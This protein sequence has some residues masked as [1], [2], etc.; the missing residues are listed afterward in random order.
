MVL[1]RGVFNKAR[2]H[3]ANSDA[4]KAWHEEGILPRVQDVFEAVYYATK[5]CIR[6][7][8]IA[9]ISE[10]I[11]SEKIRSDIAACKEASRR[12]QRGRVH[13]AERHE[14]PARTYPLEAMEKDHGTNP[15]I[16]FDDVKNTLEL[17]EH[18]RSFQ[19]LVKSADPK[20][21]PRSVVQLSEELLAVLELL[22]ARCSATLRDNLNIG[23]RLETQAET[24]QSTARTAAEQVKH[25]LRALRQ[26]VQDESAP[27]TFVDSILKAQ[28]VLENLEGCLESG[29]R[30]K[31]DLVDKQRL[32]TTG[33]GRHAEARDK[34]AKIRSLVH[35]TTGLGESA[36][37][38]LQAF[39][40]SISYAGWP[41]PIS[42]SSANSVPAPTLLQHMRNTPKHD[43]AYQPDSSPLHKRDDT[44]CSPSCT[45]PASTA[46]HWDSEQPADASV[47]VANGT[48]DSYK[49]A[50][51]VSIN[52]SR[53][54]R[55]IETAEIAARQDLLAETSVD[56][57][58]HTG[59]TF[60]L[61]VKI[62]WSRRPSST[63]DLPAPW[64]D[65]TNS[66]GSM[67][68][69]TKSHHVAG[70]Q[71]PVSAPAN[72]NNRA[73]KLA[74]LSA[75]LPAALPAQDREDF[76]ADLQDG[77][78]TDDQSV[79]QCAVDCDRPDSVRSEL[80]SLGSVQH[81]EFGRAV[82]DGRTDL[83]KTEPAGVVRSR[84]D[85]M[86]SLASHG[87]EEMTARRQPRLAPINGRRS[88]WTSMGSS[89]S[90]PVQKSLADEHL[91]SVDIALDVLRSSNVPSPIPRSSRIRRP[92]CPSVVHRSPPLAPR[93]MSPVISHREQSPPVTAAATASNVH[94]SP[95]LPQRAMSV[96]SHRSVKDWA[97]IAADKMMRRQT[98]LSPRSS[99][100]AEYVAADPDYASNQPVRATCSAAAS[101]G[102]RV[103]ANMVDVSKA[104][105][106]ETPRLSPLPDLRR[107]Q[108]TP[109]TMPVPPAGP[110][111]FRSPRLVSG[112]P[113]RTV[114]RR[115][116]DAQGNTQ[117]HDDLPSRTVTRRASDA[118]GNTQAHDDLPGVFNSITR[119]HTGWRGGQGRGLGEVEQQHVRTA[120]VHV[121][122]A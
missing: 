121:Y 78:S 89:S 40:E 5:D 59:D 17:E 13:A 44:A 64:A 33:L 55:R 83:I 60:S 80:S 22:K 94:Q 2:V 101:D 98:P 18:I 10:K 84:H 90:P 27:A 14:S 74:R 122:A 114:T 109:Q 73:G 9:C 99:L 53:G 8:K 118:Q 113:S 67:D 6:S 20:L 97:K 93:A 87:W 32:G 7:E 106:K 95:P 57:A 39:D 107:R 110:P 58:I 120:S 35:D 105:A 34:W 50:P 43:K 63:N 52:G 30:K 11:R 16:E 62:D 79:S 96:E 47:G 66:D 46:P 37:V 23:M 104:Y 1:H 68:N 65:A 12:V 41:F 54:W 49:P 4:G 42:T 91:V 77:C 119:Q 25:V 26:H 51:S 29:R 31:L 92:S 45:S 75:A 24:T 85:L 38:C 36:E 48:A 3:L 112:M 71:R 56:C 81:F 116:S 100:E 102:S 21:V 108:R 76:K 15:K 69:V 61:D 19:D 82:T 103:V 111:A 117:A 115:A 86:K 28:I 88:P 70:H 72:C